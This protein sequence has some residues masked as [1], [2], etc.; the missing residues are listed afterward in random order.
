M[1][2][3]RSPRRAVSSTSPAPQE[4]LADGL[5]EEARV[6]AT[7]GHRE[8]ARR[9]YESALYLLREPSQAEHAATILRSIALLYF[10][11]GDFGAGDDCLTAAAAVADAIGDRFAVARTTNTMASGFW[12]RGRLDEAE[13]L[14]EKAGRQA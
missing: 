12:L 10:E 3:G 8:L 13:Q 1:S 11:D 4:G 5:I 6:A 2:D 7:S 14:Y 9:R